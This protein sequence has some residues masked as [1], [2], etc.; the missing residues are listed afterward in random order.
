MHGVKDGSNSSRVIGLDQSVNMSSQDY[1]AF[2]CD[3][4]FEENLCLEDILRDSNTPSSQS[5]SKEKHQSNPIPK[6]QDSSPLLSLATP[7]NQCINVFPKSSQTTVLY[8]WSSSPPANKE[9]SAKRRLPWHV[10]GT[11][12]LNENNYTS[13]SQV[14]LKGRRYHSPTAKSFPSA[15]AEA[16]A[17]QKDLGEFI[18]QDA[19]AAQTPV[20]PMANPESLP[21]DLT[22]TELQ[23]VKKD[24]RSRM[25]SRNSDDHLDAEQNLSTA[26]EAPAKR[27]KQS[28]IARVFLNEEQRFVL[29]M[30]VKNRTSIFYTGSAGTGKSVLLREIISSLKKMFGKDREKVAVTASTGLAAC[31]IGGVTLHSFA[32]IGLGKEDVPTLIKKIRRNKRAKSRWLRTKI[33]I[34]DE[35]SMVDGDLFD[36][37]EEIAREL[38][39]SDE[40]FGGIQLIITGDFFQ[41]PP[42]PEQEQISS[43]FS[44]EASSWKKV[45]EET[46]CLH[47]VFRQKDEEFVGMLNEMRLGKLTDQ[48]ILNFKNLERAPVYDDGLLPTELFPTRRE[49]DSANN[50][51]LKSLTGLPVTF[52]SEDSGTTVDI[53][54]RTKLLSHCMAPQRLVL[55]RDAQVMLIKNM[56]ETL[57]NGSLGRVIGFMNEKAY[58]LWSANGQDNEEPFAFEAA[59][60]QNSTYSEAASKRKALNRAMLQAS[61][62][63]GRRWPYV[64]FNTPDGTT[65][66]VLVMPEKWAYEQPNGEIVASRMQIPLILAYA[67][68]IHKSQGQ[69]LDRVKV[70]LGKVFE[71]G[72]AYVALSRAVT[73]ERLQVLNFEPRKV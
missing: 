11:K 3:D 54:Q 17:N 26:S 44:F 69:T 12:Y 10:Q 28:K 70:D 56:D 16:V 33:L 32:G 9:P 41:L 65:R 57:V 1:G 18:F 2:F 29:D 22:N 53:E 38:R 45:I 42:V 15:A 71:K 20:R 66:D 7:L 72:Q 51:R 5:L 27:L 58:Q 43:K 49:V 37:L 19:T 52:Y 14:L 4:D 24:M 46:I 68:S 47:H 62:D 39:R 30:V 40:P 25:N 8:D 67:L 73:R 36:K 64:R 59:D 35:I 50:Y 55:R 6:N 61:A 13:N 63:S 48:S 21:W 34:I 60:R 23:R 31:N